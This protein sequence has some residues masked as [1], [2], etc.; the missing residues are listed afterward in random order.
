MIDFP[1]WFV[2]L[3]FAAVAL[4]AAVPVSGPLAVVGY[5]RGSR[6]RYWNGLWYWAWSTLLSTAIITA[7]M[8]LDI[9]WCAAVLDWGLLWLLTWF[10]MPHAQRDRIRRPAP[11]Q[12]QPMPYAGWPR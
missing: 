4:G 11:A 6:H 3:M 7:C 8:L 5:L 10:L 1:D 12:P 9:F 2:A